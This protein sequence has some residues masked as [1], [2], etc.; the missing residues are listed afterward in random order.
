LT[1]P[2]R[3]R[4]LNRVQ[5]ARREPLTPHVVENGITDLLSRR[6]HGAAANKRTRRPGVGPNKHRSRADRSLP[7]SRRLARG[8]VDQHGQRRVRERIRARPHTLVLGVSAG[9]RSNGTAELAAR[10]RR[11]SLRHVATEV[12]ELRGR[13]L[14][15][16][17]KTL[18]KRRDHILK[19][20]L[21]GFVS[22]GHSSFS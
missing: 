10:T 4:A 15:R 8:R 11:K 17:D 2:S 7:E 5:L 12:R 9:R 3:R 21:E 1:N 18:L 20:V 6:L 14:L 19:W 22:R 13:L 16:K